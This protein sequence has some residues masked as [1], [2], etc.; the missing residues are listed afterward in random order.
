[1]LAIM[2][3]LTG[4]EEA[5]QKESNELISK[6]TDLGATISSLAEI[7]STENIPVEGYAVIGGLNGTGSTECPSEVRAYL[8]K[9]IRKQLSDHEPDVDKFL[10]SKDSAV[11][12]VRGLMPAAASKNQYFDLKVEA[13]PGTQTTSLEDGILYGAELQPAGSFGLTT[14]IL[15]T[16]EGSVFINTLDTSASMPDKKTGYILGGGKT[17]DEY[18]ITI[19]LKKP[20][21]KVAN[22]VRN[23][24]NERFGNNT[25]KAIS[26][27]LI[28]L[29]V[30]PKYNKQKQRFISIVKAMYLSYPEKATEERID[31]F[32]KELATSQDKYKS[33]IAL[34]AIGN[35]S[36]G[37]LAALLNSSS[38]Q[39]RLAAA[40]CMLNMGNDQGL[41]PLR[42]IAESTDSPYRLEA[43]DAITKS[44]TRNDAAAISRKLL[45]DDDFDI[46]LT[47]YEHLRELEDVM[48]V[49]KLIAGDFYL[50]EITQTQHK[51]VF[52]SLSGQP[53]IV[54]FGGPIY[55]KD[56]L[57]LQSADG[58]I[59]I[60]APPEQRYV[61]I[62]RNHPNRPNVTAKLKSSFRLDDIIQTLCEQTTEK[63]P[64]KKPGLGVSYAKVI[65]IL[66]QM[67]EK[68]A[69]DAQFYAGPTPKIH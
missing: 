64:S 52:A 13:L 2:S 1:M 40:R 44:A 58:S 4:C 48:V 68:G 30:P 56:D 65:A 9:Y 23:R 10:N 29:D 6:T 32:V 63:D 14:K 24:L 55:C 39:V 51:A 66:K 5:V 60:N 33:E 19:A 34:E 47:A 25:A 3:S 31:A 27:T 62:I 26:P 7:F 20:D 38:E 28:E 16:A 17:L 49:Q 36:C 50:E 15:A 41:Q 22:L 53:R 11:V 45:R 35:Q 54:L 67:C 61:S 42:Q 37:K 8:E 59:T 43:L 21:Y 57:F 18:N 69:V 12:T 46:R